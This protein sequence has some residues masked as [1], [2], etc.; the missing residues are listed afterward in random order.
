MASGKY[1]FDSKQV[2]LKETKR[3]FSSVFVSFL[4]FFAIT[5]VSAIVIYFL[6]ALFFSTDTE[7]RLRQENRLYSK[8]YAEMEQKDR[9]LSDVVTGLEVR[10]NEIYK[11]VFSTDAPNFETSAAF[12]PFQDGTGT[13]QDLAFRT[14]DRIDRLEDYSARIEDNFKE[15]FEAIGA[16]DFV[17]PPMNIPLGD[18]NYNFTGASV[19]MKISPFY[20]VLSEHNG[21]DLIASS[22]TD[23]HAAAGGVVS[24][25]T[26]SAKGEGKAVEITHP[27]GYVTRYSHLE[28]TLV[29]KGRRVAEGAVIG[30]VGMSGLSFAP[31][32][33]YEVLRDGVP[34]NPV[35]YF[36]STL[37]PVEY[38]RMLAV[39]ATVGQS[40]D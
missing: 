19:G 6:F 10:D 26:R 12:D 20:K 28:E 9:L 3:G 17:M 39:S 30:R 27:G 18:F 2:N 4:K 21:L 16:E 31:H 22:G 32:L 29:V 24:A 33:H 7:R 25:V 5:L 38:T 15:I 37:N 11:S 8:V 34:Q 35:N 14:R 40:M 1:T 23:V 36:F 13:D